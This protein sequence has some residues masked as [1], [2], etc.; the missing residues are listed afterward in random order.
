MKKCM[1]KGFFFSLDG[2][3][4]LILFGVFLA[5]IYSYYLS[6]PSLNQQLYVSE[7]LLDV[8]SNVKINEID[9]N[10]YTEVKR[11]VEQ[12]VINNTDKTIFEVL[13]DFSVN[14]H[15][16]PDTDSLVRD[17][18][19]GSATGGAGGV[20]PKQYGLGIELIKDNQAREVYGGQA[21][22]PN[23]VVRQRLVSG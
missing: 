17:V 10:S 5:M 18:I 8:F 21:N 12:N 2:F 20:V 22:K 15:E 11:L 4:A 16:Y 3:F 6:A 1:K 13:S 23:V 9:L 7:D 14:K 19:G